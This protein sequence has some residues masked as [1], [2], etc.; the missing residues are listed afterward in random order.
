GRRIGGG[1]HPPY[2]TTSPCRCYPGASWW[3]VGVMCWRS[4][5]A[6]VLAESRRVTRL[7][8]RS[9]A[10]LLSHPRQSRRFQASDVVVSRPSRRLTSTARRA[11][12]TR[13]LYAIN[14]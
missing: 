10:P 7:D 11:G 1:C 8:P 5:L 13:N 14:Q 2:E 3:S 9:V 4:A 6:G 12:I